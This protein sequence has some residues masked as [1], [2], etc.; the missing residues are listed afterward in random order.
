MMV[1]TSAVMVSAAPV[2]VAAV[3]VVMT[4]G[5][6]CSGVGGCP[7]GHARRERDEYGHD[8]PQ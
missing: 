5:G 6:R 2:V 7:Y 4:R 1:M 3:T 8:D